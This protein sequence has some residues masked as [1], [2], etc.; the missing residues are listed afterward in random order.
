VDFTLAKTNLVNYFPVILD[1]AFVDHGKPNPEIYLKVAAALNMDPQ[2]CIVFEDSLSGVTAG[3]SAG[4]KVVGVTTTHSGEELSET[5][6]VI[7]DFEDLNPE[8]LVT[9]LFG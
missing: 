2:N 9:T 4:C 6:Y 5:D 1:E 3:K 7:D 8:R